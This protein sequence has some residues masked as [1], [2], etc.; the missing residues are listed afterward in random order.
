MKATREMVSSFLTAPE[1]HGE[2][3]AVYA[4]VDRFDEAMGSALRRCGRASPVERADRLADQALWGA[5]VGLS[6]VP[7]LFG[8]PMCGSATELAGLAAPV[9]LG[10]LVAVIHGSRTALAREQRSFPMERV[11]PIADLLGDSPKSAFVKAALAQRAASYLRTLRD[12]DVQGAE[13]I[14]DALRTLQAA[15]DELPEN[16]RRRAL[17]WL[18]ARSRSLRRILERTCG[19]AG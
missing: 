16:V 6:G 15:R 1:R 19:G 13:A 17:L 8:S 10:S 5:L 12:R 3:Q 7:F 11:R 4:A 2:R 9:V 18:D 14:A